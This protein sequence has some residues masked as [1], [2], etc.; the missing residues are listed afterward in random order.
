MPYLLIDPSETLDY[1][2]DWSDMLDDVGSPSDTISSSTWAVTPQEGSP[3][4]PD[5]KS[6]TNTA[7]TTTIFLYNCV[8]GGVYQVTN[9]IVTG[10]GRT[11]ERSITVR[12]ANR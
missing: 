3:Q 1:T 2:C 12:C 11:H 5:I 9:T 7:T 6:S 8:R 10:Q 4:Q